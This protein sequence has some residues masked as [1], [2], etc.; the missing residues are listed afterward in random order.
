MSDPDDQLRRLLHAAKAPNTEPPETPPF[1]LATR[2]LAA[3]RSKSTESTAR[4]AFAEA[5][6]QAVLWSCGLAFVALIFSLSDWQ[7]YRELSR[8]PGAEMRFAN[9]ALRSHMP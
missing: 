8:W 4:I 5:C 9:S 1:G 3:V 7:S 6:R 2:V